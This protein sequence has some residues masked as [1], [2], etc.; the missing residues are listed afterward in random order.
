MIHVVSLSGGKDST[1]LALALRQR[2]PRDYLY[3]FNP[4]GN[5]LPE[6]QWHWA[7]LERRLGVNL[8]P[9]GCGRTLDDLIQI[10]QALPSWRMRWCT[11]MLKIEPTVQWLRENA[12]CV[13][14][15]GLRADEEVEERS[16]IYGEIEG[17]TFRYPLREWGWNIDDVWAYLA[18][19]GIKIPKRTDCA[20]CYDQRIVECK[21]LWREH[22]DIY[23]EAVE[24]EEM[25]GNTFRSPGRDSWPAGLAEMREHFENDRRVRGEKFQLPL[26]EDVDPKMKKCRVCSL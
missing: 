22:P 1:A 25:I 18:E 17:V 19:Q 23:Q 9:V 26:W 15:V 13:S 8:T 7:E 11:R 16:G 14:Y 3:L 24:R 10:Q 21:N 12:P 20:W 6:M 4:T 5:E 2:E